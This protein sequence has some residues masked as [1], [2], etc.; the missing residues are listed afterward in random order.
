MAAQD[1][2]S[3]NNV[4][5]GALS[6]DIRALRI[7]LIGYGEVGSIFAAALVQAGV[8]LV[9]A[10]DVLIDQPAWADTARKRAATASVRLAMSTRDTAGEADL[11]ICAVTAAAARTAAEQVAR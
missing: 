2:P 7:A 1:S 4:P 3:P 11:V 5:R 8:Q 6:G 10:F 9:S